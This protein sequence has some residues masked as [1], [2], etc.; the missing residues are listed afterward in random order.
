MSTQLPPEQIPETADAPRLDTRCRTASDCAI[1]N[2]GNCCGAMPACVNR[3]SPTN[4]EAVKAQCARNRMM[5]TC[6]FKDVQSCSCVAGTCQDS[7]G[8]AVEAK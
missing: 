7:S 1:K 6:G 8:P 2:V 3:N 5:S 4:P